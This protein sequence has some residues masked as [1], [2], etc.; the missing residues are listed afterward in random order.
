MKPNRHFI[1]AV[2][3]LMVCSAQA[4]ENNK[5]LNLNSVQLELGGHGL[6]YSLNYERILFNTDIF[7]IAGQV[8]FS[9]YPPFIGFIDYWIPISINEIFSIR[10]HHIE[11]GVGIIINRVSSRDS[12]NIATD[13]DWEGFLSARIGYRYQKPNGRFIFR[14]GFTPI[15]ESNFLSSMKTVSDFGFITEFHPLPAVSFGYSF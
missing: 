13:W 1:F 3:I 9:Y 4:Q 5:Y 11:L 10:N 7:K 12:E 15:I 2:L 6:A 8:G 14:A